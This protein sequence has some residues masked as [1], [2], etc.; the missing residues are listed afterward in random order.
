MGWRGLSLLDVG[1]SAGA[2][3]DGLADEPRKDHDGQDVGQGV[4]DLHGH[5][6]S[7]QVD[8]LE[9]QRHGLE[10]AEE[11]AGAERV[12]SSPAQF[13]GEAEFLFEGSAY[14]LT[15]DN[16]ALLEAEG[17][18]N[19]SM[20][21]W[22]PQLALAL[23]CLFFIGMRLDQVAHRRT[24]SV[25]CRFE[26]LAVAQHFLLD[27]IGLAQDRQLVFEGSDQV[28]NGV[29]LLL[30]CARTSPSGTAA[31]PRAPA[32]QG[33]LKLPVLGIRRISR[34]VQTL[35]F[36]GRRANISLCGR[37]FTGAAAGSPTVSSRFCAR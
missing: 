12:M 25:G 15:I 21:D 1:L 16:M 11:H 9:T 13:S 7:A 31:T 19:Q 23:Q 4:H 26:H 30:R 20:L 14:R 3:R 24:L 33:A 2:W 5:G 34:L 28:G 6:E 22:A 35:G 10:K 29:P 27:R 18:L 37:Q 8:V 36:L 32:C 17:A